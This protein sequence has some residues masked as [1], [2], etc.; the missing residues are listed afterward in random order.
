MKFVWQ[1]YYIIK[2]LYCKPLLQ[3]NWAKLKLFVTTST[4]GGSSRQ[5][6]FFENIGYYNKLSLGVGGSLPRL[7]DYCFPSKYLFKASVY[8]VSLFSAINTCCAI[9]CFFRRLF[10]FR[11]FFLFFYLWNS[12]VYIFLYTNRN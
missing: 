7:S 9:G 3:K 10:L 6:F 2:N 12:K 1:I 4:V 5:P 11:A 8:L